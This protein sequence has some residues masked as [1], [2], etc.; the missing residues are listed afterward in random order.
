MAMSSRE[1]SLNYLIRHEVEKS[2]I[3]FKDGIENIDYIECKICGLKRTYLNPKHLKNR[4]NLTKEEYLKLF[5]DAKLMSD[6]KKELQ[7]KIAIG[8]IS[9]KGRKL[10]QDHKNKISIS[11]LDNNSFAGK[12]HKVSS[13][14]KAK[15]SREKTLLEKYGVDNPMKIPEVADRVSE[16]AAKGIIRGKYHKQGY[17]YSIKNNKTFL[18]RSSW[19][20]IYLNILEF[21]DD[22]I[23]YD[24]EPFI[25]K[26][27]F[28]GHI[29]NYVPDFIIND[30]YIQEI[31]PKYKL[32]FPKTIA[33]IE[34]GY[35]FAEE[36]GYS[37]EVISDDQMRTFESILL[38]LNFK[39]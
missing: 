13:M 2:L 11:Q 8:N 10:S 37:Y 16:N 35:K 30:R 31:K 21:S 25:I 5:P 15:D 23:K 19:E 14:L 28:E 3:K 12:T 7:S 6:Y 27:E 17:F 24:M 38:Y 34:A 36:N 29:R 32:E 1:R 39:R 18:Y 4:H 33:K 9:T 26:Y 20:E 22:V